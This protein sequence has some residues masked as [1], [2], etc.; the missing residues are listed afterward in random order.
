MAGFRY[1]AVDAAGYPCGVGDNLT[2]FIG[3]ADTAQHDGI[4]YYYMFAGIPNSVNFYDN[5]KQPHPPS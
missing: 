3:T 5:R 1:G 2:V 4:T